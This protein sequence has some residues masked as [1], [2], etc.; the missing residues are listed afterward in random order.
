MLASDIEPHALRAVVQ[1]AVD[2]AQNGNEGRRVGALFFLGDEAEVLRRSQPLILD[3]L[4]GHPTHDRRVVDPAVHGTIRE[5]ALL[6]GAFVVSADGVVLSAARC[7][8]VSTANIDLPPGFGSRH[9]AA[10][11]L[12][13]ETDALAIVVSQSAR[14]VRLFHDGELVEEVA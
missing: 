2:L 10:A 4:A 12:T 8:D 14:T 5:L 3:P 9:L 6:D 13:R 1:I 11:S 7:V